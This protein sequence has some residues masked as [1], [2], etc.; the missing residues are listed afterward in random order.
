MRK[1]AHRAVRLQEPALQVPVI[2]K[3][4]I[5]MG[6]GE[7]VAD[8]K[9]VESAAADLALIAGQKAVITKARKS[10]ATYKL[11]ARPGDRLQ[12][13]AAQER[14]CTSF[15]D[16][17]INIALPRVRDFRGLNAEELRRPRQLHA[18]HQGAHHLPG[19]RLRQ[20]GRHLGH[21]H[22]GLH[23]RANG[24]RGARAVDGFQLPVPAVRAKALKR[25]KP[26]DLNGEEEFDREEQPAPPAGQE[27]FG[28]ARAAQ[29][30]RARHAQADGRALRRRAQA[31]GTAAQFLCH[32]H[33]QP[34]RD[35]GRPRGYY[36][37]HKLSRIAL[38]D[39]GSKG[40]IPGL[41]KSSW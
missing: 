30:D 31:R 22:H 40:M 37:K 33:P 35:D 36:R 32:P 12:G 29:G 27:I 3:V 4:V 21:G 19:D 5:N 28:P 23:Q 1:Q 16:R 7:G 11:R 15:V 39:L 10:I 8:R 24:R 17:L 14:A 18:R 26:G 20:G 2:E 9:K 34:L 41:L 38:R 6:I 13:D 25:G